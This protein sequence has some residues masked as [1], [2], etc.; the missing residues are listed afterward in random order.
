MA[1]A[2]MIYG[3]YAAKVWVCIIALWWYIITM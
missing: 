1:F 3:S 2:F